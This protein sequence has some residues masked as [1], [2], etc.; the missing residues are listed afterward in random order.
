MGPTRRAARR[1]SSAAGSRCRSRRRR[2]RRERAFGH[3]PRGG[4]LREVHDLRRQGHVPRR[5]HVHGSRRRRPRHLHSASVQGRLGLQET[6]SPA[7][8]SAA[9]V[10]GLRRVLLRRRVRGSPLVRARSAKLRVQSVQRVHRRSHR[11]LR[12]QREGTRVHL[13]SRLVRLQRSRRLRAD[14]LLP[15]QRLHSSAWWSRGTAAGSRRRGLARGTGSRRP[16]RG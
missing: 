10:S 3:P 12:E 16:R 13:R 6:P 7:V 9:D 11:R 5:R 2:R 1:V 4:A 15:A 14:P 8:R